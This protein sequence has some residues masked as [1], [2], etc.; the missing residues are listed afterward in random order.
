MLCR[1]WRGMLFRPY[2]KRE[3]S[4]RLQLRQ[5][6][7]LV[8]SIRF[9]AAQT[10]CLQQFAAKVIDWAT[11]DVAFAASLVLSGHSDFGS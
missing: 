8:P 1:S 7:G 4:P 11:T 9:G 3:L 2:G 6:R 10:G 5:S